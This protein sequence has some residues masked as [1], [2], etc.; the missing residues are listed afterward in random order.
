[1]SEAL[2]SSIMVQTAGRAPD[3]CRRHEGR[4]ERGV[5]TLHVVRDRKGRLWAAEIQPHCPQEF[6]M[7]LYAGRPAPGVTLLIPVYG[8]VTADTLPDGSWPR[9]ALVELAQA[10]EAAA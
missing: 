9:D 10:R 6:D 8:P 5:E 7:T 1:M 3:W 2:A 4:I